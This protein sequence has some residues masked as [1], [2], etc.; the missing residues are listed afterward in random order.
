MTEPHARALG[1]IRREYER[2]SRE[3][4]V[5]Y[6][7]LEHPGNLFMYTRRTEEVIRT[8]TPLG[9]FPLSG[10]DILEVGCGSGDW[11]V[12]FQKWA[13]DPKRVCGIELD[14]KRAQ[15]A[16]ERLPA[17]DIRIGDASRLPWPGGKFDL[18]LQSTVFTSILETSLKAAIAR[19]MLRVLKPGGFILWYDF[20][21]SNPGNPH[22]RGIGK[23]E[24]RGLFRGT[25]IWFRSITLAPP[26]ARRL[27]PRSVS[28]CTFLERLGFLNTHYLAVIRK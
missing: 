26:L 12:D 14:Q 16:R 18:V 2:R 20:R 7:S 9:F 24:I 15:L 25:R 13:A 10:R 11:L 23:R 22:V 21:V 3:I 28:A 8:L 17:A 6:Y 5:D 27:A 4:P 19:E 1:R